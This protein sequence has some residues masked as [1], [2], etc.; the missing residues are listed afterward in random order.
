MRS[1][2]SI[3]EMGPGCRRYAQRPAASW[4][5]DTR[6]LKEDCSFSPLFIQAAERTAQRREERKKD[7]ST[8]KKRRSYK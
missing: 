2:T 1:I 4:L 8:A 7:A 5:R 3:A 6:G